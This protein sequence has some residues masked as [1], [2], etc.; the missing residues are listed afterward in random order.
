LSIF[1]FS[2]TAPQVVQGTPQLQRLRIGDPAKAGALHEK[3][4]F[5]G[6][7]GSRLLMIAKATARHDNFYL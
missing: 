7:A 6:D 1:V 2:K 3:V 4:L 5:S